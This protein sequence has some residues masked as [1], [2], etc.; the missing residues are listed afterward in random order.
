M[1]DKYC[2]IGATRGTGLLITQKLIEEGRNVKVLVRNRHK[3]LDVFGSDA[4]VVEA[5][6]TQAE[7]LHAVINSDVCTLF[8]TVDITGGIGGRGFFAPKARIRQITYDGLVN[9]VEAAKQGGFMGRFVL[10]SVMGMEQPSF[11]W[12]LLNFIKA[13]LRRNITDREHYL[14]CSGLEFTIIRP[15][16]LTDDK[17]GLKKVAINQI[18]RPLTL[19]E[20]LPREDLA[21][22]MILAADNLNCRN[23]TFNAYSEPTSAQNYKETIAQLNELS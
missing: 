1:T 6:V 18:H 12:T 4:E 2:I 15:P 16:G 22:L 7:T 14:K 8:F 21:K 20:T 23:K 11:A 10:L 19:S 3:A 13:G 9:T 17:G 5:D